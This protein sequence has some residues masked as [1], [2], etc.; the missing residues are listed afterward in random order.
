MERISP[1]AS[2]PA[3]FVPVNQQQV[4]TFAYD[5]ICV[6]VTVKHLSLPLI[7]IIEKLLS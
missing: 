1:D 7:V 6:V 5:Q 2:V 4:L 3:L